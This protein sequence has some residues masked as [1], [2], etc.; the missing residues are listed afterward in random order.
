MR[1]METDMTRS[2]IL[3]LQNSYTFLAKNMLSLL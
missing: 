2:Q 1:S 3:L